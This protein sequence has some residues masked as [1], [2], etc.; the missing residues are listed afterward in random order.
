MDAALEALRKLVIPEAVR[1]DISALFS[2]PIVAD[3]LE[4]ALATIR[5]EIEKALADGRPVVLV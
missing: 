1:I 4:A 3:T 5:A 2:D